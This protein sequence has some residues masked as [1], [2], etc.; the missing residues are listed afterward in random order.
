MAPSPR[1]L[2][3][4]ARKMH[5]DGRKTEA[6]GTYRQLI[7]SNPRNHQA[8]SSLGVLLGESGRLNE[9]IQSLEQASA[10]E[11]NPTYLTQLGVVYRLA[12]MLDAAA[13]S[14]GRILE[15]EPGFP[16]AR[17]NL[18]S[19][20]MD[21][22]ADAHALPLLDEALR[23]GPDG[24]RLRAAASRASFNLGQV[25]RALMDA[26]RAVELAP[27]V[28]S[29]RR[30]L[31]DLLDAHGEKA[32]AI[33]SYRRAVELDGSD[34]AAHSALIVAMLS[35]PD[36]GA[37]D[38]YV[39]ARAWAER[40][41]APLR[42]RL[43]LPSNDKDPERRLRI[44][45]VS[46]DFR[47]H[48]IQQFLVPL[49]EHHDQSAVEI[50]LYSSVDRPDVATDWY[51]HFAGNNFR[52]IRQMDDVSA[53][54]LVRSDRIDILVDLALHSSAGRLR[55]FACRPAPVQISWLGYVGTPGLDTIDY[56]ITD[57]VLDP[58]GGNLGFYSETCL[59]LPETLWCYSALDSTLEVNA[60]PALS[61]H[62]VTFGCQNAYRKLHP[63]LLALWGRVLGKVPGS[64]LFLHADEHARERL[65]LNLAREGVEADRIEFGGRAPRLEYLRRY[66]RI[67]I[68]LD[69]FPFNGATT[70]LDAAWMGVPVVTLS[71]ASPL[72]RAGA[73]I[74]MNLGLPELVAR[75]EE[76]F[77]AE[78]VALA[79]DLNRLSELR[80]GLRRRLATSPLGNAPVYAR[81]VEAAYR[82]AWRRYCSPTVT[83]S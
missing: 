59:H 69:T 29:Y 40:H 66:Q 52:D 9:A 72:Q 76:A 51:R 77:V 45:Y 8:L 39:E 3:A 80:A 83:S 46:P 7:R 53:A 22:G 27:G 12:G 26:R 24:G 68:G 47:E 65:Q 49:L 37:N 44:G 54:K 30:Q 67:D 25:D 50:F 81:H 18:A 48:A 32:L 58:P 13:E 56:R 21:A 55:I 2:L 38:H 41:A 70:T 5:R 33:A 64:R 60:L 15:V 62:R 31:G 16:D 71:G 20:L 36:Y 17:L 6:E 14:F 75:S 82:T 28:A 11:V 1:Q 19:I 79:S 35:S 23:L 57:N 78:A 34:H 73:S 4:Q 63:G 74:M 43:P 61:A 10:I 42:G